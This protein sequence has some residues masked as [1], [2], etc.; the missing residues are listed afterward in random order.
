MTAN[1]VT[2]A[3]PTNANA[4]VQALLERRFQIKCEQDALAKEAKE[5]DAQLM[6][7]GI[8]SANVQ[9]RNGTLE[10]HFGP[11]TIETVDL[12]KV[13]VCDKEAVYTAK[14]N[15][16]LSKT[17]IKAGIGKL[18]LAD[19]KSAKV[20]SEDD[21]KRATIVVGCMPRLEFRAAKKVSE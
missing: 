7:T 4:D 14:V 16:K 13:R 20:L 6:A 11:N 1:V 5:I 12:D 15:A 18:T 10:C 21:L 9:F 3:Q 8:A 2:E 19:F 17:A